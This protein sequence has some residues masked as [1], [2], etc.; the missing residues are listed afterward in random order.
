MVCPIIQVSN[1]CLSS[2]TKKLLRSRI[3][4]HCCP[5]SLGCMAITFSSCGLSQIFPTFYFCCDSLHSQIPLHLLFLLR[6]LDRSLGPAGA[7]APPYY[8]YLYGACFFLFF[9]WQVP[10]GGGVALSILVLV[11]GLLFPFLFLTGLAGWHWWRAG[12]PCVEGAWVHGW[13]AP[14]A[15]GSFYYFCLCSNDRYQN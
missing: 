9:F 7:M 2:R 3:S 13:G 11:W 12:R 6:L 5:T 15:G 14:G 1:G 4:G 8:L 10:A